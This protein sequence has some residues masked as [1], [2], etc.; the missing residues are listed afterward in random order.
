MVWADTN[1]GSVSDGHGESNEGR[2]VMAD[3]GAFHAWG[4]F[5]KVVPVRLRTGTD[6]MGGLKQVCEAHGVKHGALLAGIGSLRK[7]TYQV[8]TPKPETKLGAGYTEPQV[9]PGPVEIVSLQGVIFQSEEGETLLHVHGTFS[10]K[11]GKVYAGHVVAGENPVLATLDGLIAEVADVRLIR[12]MDAEVGL[13][14][15]TPEQ[16]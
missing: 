14:L 3:V 5:G 4:R 7:M 2:K 10:D 9:V 12:R 1:G 11:D 13:G 16:L 8:L 15:Y 6:V